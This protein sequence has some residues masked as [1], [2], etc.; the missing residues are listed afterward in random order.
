MK[1]IALVLSILLSLFVAVSC[2]PIWQDEGAPAVEEGST[3]KKVLNTSDG[4]VFPFTLDE[5]KQPVNFLLIGSDQRE[6]EPARADVLMVAQYRPE[7]STIKIISI[8]RD[9]FVEIP[10]YEKSKINHAYSWGGEELLA[11]TIQKNFN[12]NIHHTIKIDFNKFISMMDL[13]FPEGV[14]VTVTEPMIAHWNWSREPGE[15]VLKGEEILQYVRFRGDSQNDFG[16]VERQQE[17]MSLAEKSLMEKMET[18]E[19]MK[20]LVSLIREGLKNVETS[21]PISEILKYGMSVMLH[22]IDKVDTLRIPVEGSFT[23]LKAAHAGLVLEMDEQKNREA[24]MY[25][26]GSSHHE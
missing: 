26:L 18:G 21:T 2:S 22:P 5:N 16:R 14:P 7:S 3:P 19:G 12:L 13:V 20:T 8:M 23:D 4:S 17:I 10:G 9:T 11:D 15:N 1:K 25:F 6:N 24:I